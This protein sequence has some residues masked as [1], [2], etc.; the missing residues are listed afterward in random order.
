[1]P[2]TTAQHLA[3]DLLR[4]E[5]TVLWLGL[6]VALTQVVSILFELTFLGVLQTAIPVTDP[7]SAFLV[8]F[9]NVQDLVALA[10]T[11]VVTPFLLS[12][13]SLARVHFLI[14]AV[15]ICTALVVF[16]HPNL[17]TATAAFFMF[18]TLDY[19]LF[20]AAKEVL[21]IPLSFASRYRAKQLIDGVIYRTSKGVTSGMISA[22]TA[23]A[24][25]LKATLVYPPACCVAL[26]GWIFFVAR[27]TRS[28]PKPSEPGEGTHRSM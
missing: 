22:A 19:D 1:A 15:H 17:W 14:P 3:L 2:K 4:K 25:T 10:L 27:L 11:F 21:Y 24:G 7:R 5:P 9:W 28:L 13:L 8:R 26:L 12:R 18:K 20:G 6:I 23:A 16:F